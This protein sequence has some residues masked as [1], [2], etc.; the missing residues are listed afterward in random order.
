M[1]T[2]ALY[3]LP[4]GFVLWSFQLD[5]QGDVWKDHQKVNSFCSLLTTLSTTHQRTPG[6]KTRW[7]T[8]FGSSLSLSFLLFI[9]ALPMLKQEKFSERIHSV[10]SWSSIFHEWN[11]AESPLVSHVAACTVEHSHWSDLTTKRRELEP[12]R[13]T[14]KGHCWSV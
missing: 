12:A 3:D 13:K 6:T 8:W 2:V 10:N 1:V 14:R 9:L 5:L 7:P 11:L 4:G